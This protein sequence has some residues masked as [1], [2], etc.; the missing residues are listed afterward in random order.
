MRILKVVC[1]SAFAAAKTI[2]KEDEG[3]LTINLE[4]G[5][6]SCLI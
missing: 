3:A 5:T 4:K 2:P 6:K 1:L